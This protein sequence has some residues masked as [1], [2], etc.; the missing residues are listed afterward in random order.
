MA[1]KNERKRVA[2]LECDPLVYRR[3]VPNDAFEASQIGGVA[4][5]EE[6]SLVGR[7]MLSD[8]SGA[9]SRL[10][11]Y[12]TLNETDVI[13]LER[14]GSGGASIRAYLVRNE[15][16]AET[17][18]TLIHVGD[19]VVLCGQTEIDQK[20]DE[21]V[22]V[23][24]QVEV[25]SKAIT[26]VYDKNVDFRKRSNL[27]NHRHLQLLRDEDH[28]AEFQ[29]YTRVYKGIRQYLYAQ[30]YEE[31]CLPV[32]QETFE[33]G[34]ATPF[35]TYVVDR[36]CDMYLRLTAEIFLRKLV[37]AGFTK[38]FEIGTSF[39]NQGATPTM[40][41]VF[42]ILELYRAYA[43]EGEMEHVLRG[44]IQAVLMEVYG[45][46]T[47]PTDDGDIDCSGSWGS[48]DLNDELFR[49]T[50]MQYDEQA[51]VEQ[52]A[53]ILDA[54]GVSRPV[55]LNNYTVGTE[56]YVHLMLKYRQPTFLKGLPAATSPLNKLRDDGST[57]DETLLVINGMLV[58]DI[59]NAERDPRV[60]RERMESQMAFREHDEVGVNEELLQAM[61]YGLPPCRGIGM[62][63]ERLLMLLFNKKE[64]R[65]VKIF[66]IF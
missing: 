51:S 25:L 12:H 4:V 8:K 62:G 45:R 15:K 26:N 34:L 18:N 66:P 56:L 17:M 14:I 40:N 52:N 53:S 21:M 43:K 42:S 46:M 19:V 58:A 23:A 7:L 22:F 36:D 50:G 20:S 1:K 30:G 13:E 39:R 37:I 10:G 2:A 60:L 44:M 9:V 59:V 5:G 29:A 54:L 28:L 49:L 61:A 35:K 48:I 3:E 64:I 38:S 32:L 31:V 55:V 11:V 65:E 27:H 63:L 57:I 6:V 24:R 47:I 33:A 41:P 16:N